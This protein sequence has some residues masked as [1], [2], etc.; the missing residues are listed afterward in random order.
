MELALT[1]E[2]RLE[3][4]NINLRRQI[5]EINVSRE[6]QILDAKQSNIV[7]SVNKRL[8]IDLNEYKINVE[9]G[10]LTKPEQN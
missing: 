1:N 6:V 3:L 2:E 7:E 4:Q 9:T 10:E 5:L 8:N